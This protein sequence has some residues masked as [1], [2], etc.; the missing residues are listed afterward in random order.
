MKR[1]GVFDEATKPKATMMY[2]KF[3]R[4]KSSK[5][6]LGLAFGLILIDRTGPCLPCSG[7]S[8]GKAVATDLQLRADFG[9]SIRSRSQRSGILD[10]ILALGI[11]MLMAGLMLVHLHPSK[12][13]LPT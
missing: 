11:R 3:G 5:G 4:W 9:P 7:P 6:W 2:C 10:Y 12:D 1:G 13:T 8:E